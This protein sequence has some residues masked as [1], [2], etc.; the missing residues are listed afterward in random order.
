[1]RLFLLSISFFLLVISSFAANW[2]PLPFKISYFGKRGPANGYGQPLP[3][4][5]WFLDALQLDSSW[6]TSAGRFRGRSVPNPTQWNDMYPFGYLTQPIFLNTVLQTSADSQIVRLRNIPFAHPVHSSG[7]DQFIFYPGR[8]T[9]G[10]KVLE[11]N[12]V[13]SGSFQ[14][15]DSD[16]QADGYLVSTGV[17]QIYGVTDSIRR[18]VINNKTFVWS[19]TFGFMGLPGLMEKQFGIKD[20]ALGLKDYDSEGSL[21]Y[22]S[23]SDTLHFRTRHYYK[24]Y[25]NTILNYSDIRSS[26]MEYPYNGNPQ[27]CKYRNVVSDTGSVYGIEYHEIK[28]VAGTIIYPLGTLENNVYHG[29]WMGDDG[30]YL[31]IRMSSMVMDAVTPYFLSTCGPNPFLSTTGGFAYTQLGALIYETSTSSF[32]FFISS[33]NQCATGAPLRPVTITSVQ[34]KSAVREVVVSPNPGLNR[35]RIQGYPGLFT[36]Y[37]LSGKAVLQT[38]IDHDSEPEVSALPSGLYHFSI[39]DP[40]GKVVTGK[41]VKQ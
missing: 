22:P 32:P 21:V 29:G 16:Y 14:E 11:V 18:V 38:R 31:R 25:N 39:T 41:W 36:L 7:E 37:D 23:L 30:K 27:S 24:D 17:G 20:V 33:Q 12:V 4:T 5:G 13:G 26:V 1:M 34:D 10:Q 3:A 2:H 28:Y 6:T 40:I 19:K 9:P 8:R 15:F 35:L